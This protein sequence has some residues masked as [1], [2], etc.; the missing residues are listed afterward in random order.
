M[1]NVDIVTAN[2]NHVFWPKKLSAI[3]AAIRKRHSRSARQKYAS[4]IT[5]PTKKQFILAGSIDGCGNN[6]NT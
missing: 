5:T 4:E 6:P 3:A 1:R 2:P